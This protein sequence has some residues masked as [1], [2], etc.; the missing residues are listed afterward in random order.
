MCLVGSKNI[1]I[2]SFGYTVGYTKIHQEGPEIAREASYIILFIYKLLASYNY[3]VK[4]VCTLDSSCM[5]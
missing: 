4:Y 1:A 2:M 5:H 3:Y